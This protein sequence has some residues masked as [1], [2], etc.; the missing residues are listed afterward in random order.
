MGGCGAGCFL[1]MAP[2]REDEAEASGDL[3]CLRVDP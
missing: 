2:S 3:L 1:R